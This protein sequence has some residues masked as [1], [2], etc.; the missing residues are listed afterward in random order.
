MQDDLHELFLLAARF[1]YKKYKKTGG[2]QGKLAAKLGITNSYLSSITSGARKAS[3]DLQN[4]IAKILY[5]PYDKFLLVGRRIKE[6]LDPLEEEK[7]KPVDSVEHL[8]ARLT[9]YVM[10]HQRIEKELQVSQEK[11]RD[12]S[13][14]S[15]DMIFEI[16]ENFKFTYLSGKVQEVTG[17]NPNDIL[18]KQINNFLDA[19][20]NDRLQKLIS[21]SIQTQTILDTV[22]T[23]Q[24]GDQTKYRHLIA[25]PVFNPKGEF[26][27]AR[28][29][30]RDIT[31]RKIMEERIKQQNWLLQVA[32]DSIESCGMIIVA[33]DNTVLKWN[34]EYKR[35]SGLSEKTLE[36][37]DPRKYLEESKSLMAAPEQ[38]ELELA[39]ALQSKTE[40]NHTSHLLDGRILERKIMPLFKDDILIGRIGHLKDITDEANKVTG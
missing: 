15:G 4:K 13:L 6:G 21:K 19:D 25:K 34:L 23:I 16:D 38:F 31:S 14:T 17:L 20:E 26:K 30:Y 9:H 1:F 2:S 33:A 8:L 40:I 35:L 7:A 27:G 5:G 10:D 12:I 36:T 29:T 11:F 18:G 28:G 3:L 22:L 39:Q 37:R 24:V 32:L